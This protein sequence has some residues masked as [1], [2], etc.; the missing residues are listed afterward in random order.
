MKI[1]KNGLARWQM[2]EDKWEY[3]WIPSLELAS[4]IQ[5]AILSLTSAA[6]MSLCR[7][8][9]IIVTDHRDISWGMGKNSVNSSLHNVCCAPHTHGFA[10]SY[11]PLQ[12]I[13][14]HKCVQRCRE[15]TV[16]PGCSMSGA[17]QVPASIQPLVG[18][19]RT[20]REVPR[21]KKQSCKTPES[22]KICVGVFSLCWMV[23]KYEPKSTVWVV[24]EFL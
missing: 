8:L 16:Q 20:E 12:H 4:P 21:V 9:V 22:W 6:R 1:W 17:M 11:A 3:T 23:W 15:K 14:W 13:Y 7:F 10:S 18:R 19:T 5:G 24:T 2:A